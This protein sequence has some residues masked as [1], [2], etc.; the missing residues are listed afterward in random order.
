MNRRLAGRT[1][2]Q[3][4]RLLDHDEASIYCGISHANF[5]RLVTEGRLPSPVDLNGELVWDM[6]LIDKA[7]DRL[8]GQRRNT[9]D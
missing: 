8:T 6:T 5:D 4:R 1:A 9:A 7:L 2:T 3:P